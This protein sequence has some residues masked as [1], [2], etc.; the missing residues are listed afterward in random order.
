MDRG[1][2]TLGTADGDTR[3]LDRS[4]GAGP[5]RAAD[6]AGDPALGPPRADAVL[7]RPTAGASAD[8]PGE[9]PSAGQGVVLQEVWSRLSLP[10]RQRFGHCFSFMVLKA[11]GLRPCPAQEVES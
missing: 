10:D 11:L 5:G 1:T 9:G 2:V 6:R 4:A 8:L 7:P 3:I